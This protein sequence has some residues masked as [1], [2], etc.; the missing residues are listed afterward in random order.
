MIKTVIKIENKIFKRAYF[1]AE[2][3]NKSNNY[4]SSI[5]LI[6]NNKEVSA[7][8]I[9]EVM[10]LRLNIG[11]KLVLKV[12]GKDEKYAF[13]KLRGFISSKIKTDDISCIINVVK[14]KL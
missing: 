10:S 4:K 9:I 8:N 13:M 1:V 2:F 6:S 5:T 12:N 7:E 11:D 14:K 3:A